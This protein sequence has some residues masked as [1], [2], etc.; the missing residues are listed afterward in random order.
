MEK[1][2]VLGL[3]VELMDVQWLLVTMVIFVL[4]FWFHVDGGLVFQ[5]TNT[6]LLVELAP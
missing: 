3:S 2:K 1:S 6:L 5:V 4:V